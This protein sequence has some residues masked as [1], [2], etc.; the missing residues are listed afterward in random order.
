VTSVCSPSANTARSIEPHGDFHRTASPLFNHIRILAAMRFDGNQPVANVV[1]M[2]N[3]AA[4]FL[5]GA[6]VRFVVGPS[7]PR[8]VARPHSFPRGL[9][10]SG[11]R[12]DSGL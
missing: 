2:L 3:H 11:V 5:G 8:K 12:R 10:T 1:A 7:R 4:E 9:A 6:R